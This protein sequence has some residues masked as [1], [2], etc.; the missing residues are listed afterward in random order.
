MYPYGCE[1]TD[2]RYFYSG[3]NQWWDTTD[4]LTLVDTDVVE[5]YLADNPS[6]GIAVMGQETVH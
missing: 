5:E 1:T 6:I 3:D 2:R 4:G